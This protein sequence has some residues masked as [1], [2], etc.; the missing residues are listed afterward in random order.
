M[1]DLKCVVFDFDGTIADTLDLALK[2]YNRIAPEYKFKSI[3]QQELELLRAEKPQKLLKAYGITDLRLFMLL[4]R[5]RKEL[6]KHIP[7][8]RPVE[9]I[10]D[11]LYEIKNDGYKLGILTSNSVIN[12]SKFLENNSLSGIVDFIYSGKSLFGKDR[13]IRRMLENEKLSPGGVV[14]VGDETRDVEASK[15]S[16]IPVIAVSWGLHT[17]EILN[18]LH[19]DRIADRPEE[20]IAFVRLILNGYSVINPAQ[21]SQK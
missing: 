15:K 17:R 14:Y 6:G 18:S 2:I 5:M 16:G 13:V 10:R 7:E 20:L 21:T 8:I 12:V 4:L 3:G 1:N 19:P 11:S 9:G